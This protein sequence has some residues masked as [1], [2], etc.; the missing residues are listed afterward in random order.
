METPRL[1]LTR[2]TSDHLEGYYRIWS[3][4]EATQW[5][6]RGVCKTLEETRAWMS[7]LLVETN[8]DVEVYA[9]LLKPDSNSQKNEDYNMIGVV[10]THKTEP[11]PELSYILHPSAWGKGYATEALREYVR[12]YFQLKPQFDQLTAWVDTENAGSIKVLKK[13]GFVEEKM[14]KGDYVI[15]WKNPAKRDSLL[16][17]LKGR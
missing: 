2:F 15:P 6:S 11:I 10:G 14:K 9:I 12:H 8:P 13:C 1:I 5:S 4:K 3:S 16:F 7:A 17:V